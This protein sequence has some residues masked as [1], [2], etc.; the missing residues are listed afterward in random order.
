ML[1][2]LFWLAAFALCGCGGDADKGAADLKGDSTSSN[3]KTKISTAN[4]VIS[5]NEG[6]ALSIL[7]LLGEAART[8]TKF[9]WSVSPKENRFTE[10][11]G[12]GA[13]PA[14]QQSFVFTTQSINDLVYQGPKTYTLRIEGE[15]FLNAVEVSI[16]LID[17]E[18]NIELAMLPVT[19]NEGEGPA[20]LTFTLSA[21]YKKDVMFT[22]NTTQDTALDALDFMPAAGIAVIPAGQVQVTKTL[23]I[24][25]DTLFENT[26]SLTVTIANATDKINVTN[27]TGIVTIVD[28]DVAPSLSINDINPSEN[29]G[30]ADFTVSLS[31]VSGKDASVSYVATSGT[32]LVGVDFTYTLGV[33][34]IPAGQL[35]GVISVPLLDDAIYEGNENFSVDLTSPLDA[36]VSD[37]Q[38]IATIIEDENLPVLSIAA[39]AVNEDS[40]PLV[41]TVSKTGASIFAL[42]VDYTTSDGTAVA[43]TDYTATSGT[44]TIP[45]GSA[46]GTIAIPI[47]ADSSY[48]NNESLALTLSNPTGATLSTAS[49]IGTITN[50]DPLPLLTIADAAANED[51]GSIVFTVTK[52]GATDLPLSVTYTTSAVTA[53]AGSDYTT[54]SGTLT[55]LAGATTGIITVPI[56]TDAITE[57]DETFTVALSNPTGT[58]IVTAIA[59]GTIANDDAPTISGVVPATGSNIGGT[60]ITISGT[61]F[62][63]GATASVGGVACTSPNV[64]SGISFTCVTPAG[65]VGA[66]DVVLTN[67]VGSQASGTRN[68]TSSGAFT[69]IADGW[70]FGTTGHFAYPGSHF[71]TSEINNRATLSPLDLTS[72][73][74]SEFNEGVYS[75][76]TT[77]ANKLLLNASDKNQMKLNLDWMPKRANLFAYWGLDNSGVEPISGLDMTQLGTYTYSTSERV[78][79]SH[80]LDFT[81]GSGYV[82]NS[83]LFDNLNKFSMAFWTKQI[84]NDV[85]ATIYIKSD[86]WFFDRSM[87]F[88]FGD[89]AAPAD[90][91]LRADVYTTGGTA[92][93]GWYAQAFPTNE[94]IHLAVVH[95]GTSQHL[96]VNGIQVD[97]GNQVGNI[98]YYSDAMN[99]PYF[100][101]TSSYTDNDK[102]DEIGMW[103]ADLTAAEVLQIYEA[104][105][106]KYAGTYTSK[107]YDVTSANSWLD[108]DPITSLPFGKE[109]PGD[110]DSDGTANAELPAEYSAI[111]ASSEDLSNGLV[112]L[113]HFNEDSWSGAPLEVKDNSGKSFDGAAFG[114]ANTTTTGVFNGA[115]SIGA[116]QGIDFGNSV[117]NYPSTQAFSGCTW[118][119]ASSLA[120]TGAL[121]SRMKNSSPFTGW[122]V[123]THL[124][125]KIS[126]ELVAT[127][128]TDQIRVISQND[129]L[130]INTWQQFCFTYDGSSSAAGVVLYLNA[131][132]VPTT[133][134]YDNL[135]NP[136]TIAGVPF[137]IGAFQSVESFR[138]KLDEAAI[139][140]RVLTAAEIVQFY[141]R[142]ANKIQYQV[143]SCDDVNCTGEAWQGPTNDLTKWFSEAQSYAT[144]NA[145]GQGTGHIKLVN[146]LF[147]FVDYL[148]AGLSVIKNQYF[149]YRVMMSSTD[150]NDVC[151]GATPCLP[152][153]DAITMT[154]AFELATTEGRPFTTALTH[155]N[156]TLGGDCGTAGNIKLQVSPDD[157]ITYYFWNGSSW[158]VVTTAGVYA[159]AASL[160]TTNA[161]LSS[162]ATSGIFRFKALVPSQ[163]G[164]TCELSNPSIQ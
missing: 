46:F 36:T 131:M 47:A 28:D 33:V 159:Q 96:Y 67:S 79:G 137:N 42:T 99:R 49:A 126:F 116:S 95:T 60:T 44:L 123:E 107:I 27:P 130:K 122:L 141:R 38:G 156:L 68:V 6:G 110:T 106:A 64:V 29:A 125:G 82:S 41:M 155:L 10:N 24:V 51:A 12:E 89:E 90:R 161:N 4:T 83:A 39:N 154:P 92:W 53:S 84:N 121:F 63:S 14:G 148:S 150:E 145:S 43:G 136:I 76:T 62:L 56:A 88:Y 158:T 163:Y 72:N 120:T 34:T 30:T 160:V 1:L 21:P 48:E 66:A 105:K 118:L 134:T 17:D 81:S 124:S 142:G 61:G 54:A 101:N 15:N 45:A 73:S 143:R 52:T 151:T 86:N 3:W 144:I 139:W 119:N 18:T 71:T 129:L 103:N 152:G 102:F 23:D 69:Y 55:I 87:Q 132:A 77:S 13:L 58:T 37:A 91:T 50:D 40:S 7:V 117:F 133:T 5:L 146:P 65:A 97:S 85:W 149:Q 9:K 25:A 35:S 2:S 140:N 93:M 128:V 32:A 113:W 59:I 11:S 8:D 111:T 108:L 153:L 22:Y 19:V 26:E 20:T 135:V 57:S 16:A 109:L 147:T 31:E 100:G 80:G 164:K 75:G 70:N 127:A 112:G 157:G 104:Q 162:L 94:W 74:T 78:V 98:L 115:A 114:G 138:G